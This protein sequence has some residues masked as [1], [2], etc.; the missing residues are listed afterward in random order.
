MVEDSALVEDIAGPCNKL[1]R[2]FCCDAQTYLACLTFFK[3]E[4]EEA[5]EMVAKHLQGWTF[6]GRNHWVGGRPYRGEDT[7]E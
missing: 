3:G 4:E 6:L 5:L 7:C 2:N 1:A